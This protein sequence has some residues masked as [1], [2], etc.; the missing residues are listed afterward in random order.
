MV[1]KNDPN[2]VNEKSTFN[3]S[4]KKFLAIKKMLKM[5]NIIVILVFSIIA[6]KY[7]FGV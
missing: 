2:D 1:G 3:S 7:I 5:V 6:M 4:Q